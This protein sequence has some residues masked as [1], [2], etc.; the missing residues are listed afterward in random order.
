MDGRAIVDT[1]YIVALLNR[2]DDHHAWATRLLPSLRGPWLTA[3]A[4]ISESVFLL[5][6][7]GRE[8]VERLISWL[9]QGLVVSRHFLPD[10][11][12]P[13]RDEMLR[14][15][16]RWVDFADA[17]LV[18]LSDERPKLPVVSVDSADFAVYFRGRTAR[19]LFVP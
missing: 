11:L 9:E 19:R 2:D 3:E 13:V 14:Y 15:R 6:A 7:A 12:E 16:R 5:E 18:T 10:A 8:S 17:C 1:G 4:C